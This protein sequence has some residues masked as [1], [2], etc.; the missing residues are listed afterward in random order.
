MRNAQALRRAPI[1]YELGPVSA[2]PLG[3][4]RQFQLGASLVAVFRTRSG[5]IY[6]TQ[7]QCPHQGGPLV[8]GLVGEQVVVC[9]LHSFKFALQTGAAVGHGCSALK[10]YEVQVSK[11]GALRVT[12]DE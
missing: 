7:A 8:D 1:V 5:A 2:I 10:T 4:G 3:E 11:A 9:P 6:A 12:I